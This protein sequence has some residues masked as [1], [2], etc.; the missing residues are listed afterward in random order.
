M[1]GRMRR[2]LVPTAVFTLLVLVG[3]LLLSGSSVVGSLVKAL[4]VGAVFGLVRWWL[5]RRAGPRAE[6]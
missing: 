1:I 5:V 2:V 4:L 3:Y 6:G